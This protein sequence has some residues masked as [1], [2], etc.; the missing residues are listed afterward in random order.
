MIASTMGCG[1]RALEWLAKWLNFFDIKTRHYALMSYAT[2]TLDLNQL[3]L[4]KFFCG[5]IVLTF[6]VV[7]PVMWM[8]WNE[9]SINGRENPSPLLYF[10]VGTGLLSSLSMFVATFNLFRALDNSRFVVRRRIRALSW[11][12]IDWVLY[13]VSTTSTIVA[14]IAFWLVQLPAASN[15]VHIMRIQATLVQFAAIC[16]DFYLTTP[17]FRSSHVFLTLLW[18][19]VWFVI[20]FVWIACGHQPPSELINFHTWYSPVVAFSMLLLTM[21]VFFAMQ[22]LAR[23]L[24]SQTVIDDISKPSGPMK[25][26]DYV[27]SVLRKSPYGRED[28]SAKAK[29]DLMAKSQR[30]HLSPLRDSTDSSDMESGVFRIGSDASSSEDGT[31]VI[32]M[33]SWAGEPP[34]GH[35]FAQHC[36]ERDSNPARRY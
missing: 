33:G 36:H 4:W 23:R 27:D 30:A 1:G 26:D 29:Y 34:F 10:A 5:S 19:S 8:P 13:Q 25:H 12:M 7:M 24:R 31:H 22:K 2:K 16:A 35:H 28:N 32:A 14:F 6:S 9:I 21:A 17:H 3:F 20:E 15:G 11:E 18:P